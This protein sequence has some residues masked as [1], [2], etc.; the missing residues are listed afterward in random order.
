MRILADLRAVYYPI[1]A[2]VKQGWG[3]YMI[4]LRLTFEAMMQE[5]LS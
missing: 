1:S 4:V 2:V 5:G 3:T